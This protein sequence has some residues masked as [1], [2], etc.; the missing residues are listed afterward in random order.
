MRR[1]LRAMAWSRARAASASSPSASA[2]RP[3]ETSAALSSSARVGCAGASRASASTTTRLVANADARMELASLA[4]Q[5]RHQQ[6]VGV[7]AI[8]VLLG[9][10]LFADAEEVADLERDVDAADVGRVHR[11]VPAGVRV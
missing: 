7:G 1:G 4:G 10:H 9:R 2:L 11:Q 6:L 5:H 3:T 8:V